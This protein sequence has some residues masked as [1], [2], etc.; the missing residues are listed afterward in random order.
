MKEELLQMKE[1]IVKLGR[2]S[3][4]LGLLDHNLPR[5]STGSGPSTSTR[6]GQSSLER[7]LK[8]P[9]FVPNLS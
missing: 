8:P 1:E 2:T 9:P 5:L 4:A 3:K 7:W 6:I